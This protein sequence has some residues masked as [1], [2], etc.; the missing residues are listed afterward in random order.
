MGLST[1]A[2]LFYGFE[3]EEGYEFPWDDPEGCDEIEDWWM[4][5]H[6]DATEEE[7][8]GFQYVKRNPLPIEVI[9]HC[10]CEYPMYGLAI[11]KTSMTA[12]RGYPIS[13]NE[14]PYP[15]TE[16]MVELLEFCDK[17]GIEKPEKLSWVLCSQWC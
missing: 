8:Y 5:L 12:S 10:S 15:S 13:F 4:K 11:P 16:Q 3:V 7:K 9:Y 1:D 17:C 6:G 14:L 2:I